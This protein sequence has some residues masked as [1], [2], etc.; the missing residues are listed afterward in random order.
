M[1]FTSET[2]FVWPARS[3]LCFR[4][5]ELCHTREEPNFHLEFYLR[6]SRW[7]T[8]S[9]TSCWCFAKKIESTIQP[10]IGLGLHSSV[11]ED[12][13]HEAWWLACLT[14]FASLECTRQFSVF[15]CDEY[16]ERKLL[17]FATL[18]R[19]RQGEFWVHPRIVFFSLL[20]QSRLSA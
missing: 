9:E 15:G 6:F 13:D 5:L 8:V 12:V 4:T 11:V 20:C 1:N 18:A 3:R 19:S 2:S 17:S 16:I 14:S 7:I 10:V